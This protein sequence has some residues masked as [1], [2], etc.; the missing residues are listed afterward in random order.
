MALFLCSA[1][2]AVTLRQWT[3][4]EVLLDASRCFLGCICSVIVCDIFSATRVEGTTYGVANRQHIAFLINIQ[5]CAHCLAT[6]GH[7]L[8]KA[9]GAQRID[10]ADLIPA[11]MW[12]Q[13]VG[14]VP[15]AASNLGNVGCIFNALHSFT[16]VNVAT[17]IKC[18]ANINTLFKKRKTNCF[19]L[20]SVQISEIN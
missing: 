8:Y 13:Q 16:R 5:V 18:F 1:N 12:G 10:L 14:Y 20:H 3:N 2:Q 11:S 6:Y 7:W 4:S 15:S 9:M 19:S 17:W